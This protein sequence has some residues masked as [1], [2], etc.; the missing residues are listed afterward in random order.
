MVNRSSSQRAAKQ[1]GA[2]VRSSRNQQGW[3]QSRAGE[4][5]GVDAVTVRRWELGMFSPSAERIGRVAEAYGVDV[6][7]LLKAAEA[8]EQNAG[9]AVVPVNGYLNAGMRPDS[10]ATRPDTVSLPLSIMEGRPDSYCLVV[11]GDSLVPDGIHHGDFLLVSPDEVPSIGSLCVL[12]AENYF[13]AAIYVTQGSLRVRTTTGTTVD[14]EILP[15][16]LVGIVAWH[17]RKL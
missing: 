7:T 12:D 4:A 8:G 2:F 11:S 13:Y 14:V 16:Q 17:I 3:T 15:E 6:S 10:D 5:V 1:L 9:T